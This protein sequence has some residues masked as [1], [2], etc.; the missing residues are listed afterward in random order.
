MCQQTMSESVLGFCR[1]KRGHSLHTW[2]KIRLSRQIANTLMLFNASTQEFIS[3]TALHLH[4]SQ[5]LQRLKVLSCQNNNNN[6]TRSKRV[7]PVCELQADCD[8]AASH[9]LYGSA[10]D[11]S[12]IEKKNAF[13]IRM[14]K[15]VIPVCMLL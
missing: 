11:T 4:S 15:A 3:Q 12:A 10:A 8:W 6:K 7:V 9:V 2:C 14:N 5:F 1:V 13:L